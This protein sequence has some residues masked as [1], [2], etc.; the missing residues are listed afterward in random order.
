MINLN[1]SYMKLHLDGQILA[2]EASRLQ[3]GTANCNQR[4]GAAQINVSPLSQSSFFALMTAQED[5]L[6]HRN[7]IN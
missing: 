4:G 7:K 1:L 6:K 3:I 5:I 2:S